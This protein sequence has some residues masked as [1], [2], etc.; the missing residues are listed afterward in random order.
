MKWVENRLIPSFESK[1]P[2][3]KMVL[4]CDNAPYHHKREIGSLNSKTKKQMLKLY[5]QY[6]VDTV[7]LPLN[8]ERW[9]YCERMNDK[10]APTDYAFDDSTNYVVSGTVEDRGEYMLINYNRDEQE[11]TAGRNRPR[12]ANVEELKT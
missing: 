4:I 3:K 1:Y 5:D 10:D 6:A 2:N 9:R 7:E 12:V 8:D 11:Q